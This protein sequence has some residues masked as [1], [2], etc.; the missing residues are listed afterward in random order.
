MSALT[1]PPGLRAPGTFGRRGGAAGG[2]LWLLHGG[3]LSLSLR[4][5]F[6]AGLVMEALATELGALTP[7]QAAA[8]VNTVEVSGSLGRGAAG[9]A[10]AR[11]A[12]PAGSWA[13]PG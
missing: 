3:S 8:P 13:G 9:R 1:A 12:L 4:C 5:S 10:D 7:E 6:T 2:R 11:R